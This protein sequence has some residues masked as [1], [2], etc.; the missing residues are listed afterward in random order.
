MDRGG[1]VPCEGTSFAA[2]FVSGVAALVRARYPRLTA[3]QTRERIES[4]ADHPST[5][6]PDARLGYGVVNPVAAVTAA[7]ASGPAAASA[8]AGAPPLPRPASDAAMRR[9]TTV[10]AAGSLGAVTLV[11][12]GWATLRRGRRR[13]WRP[14][15]AASTDGRGARTDGLAARTDATS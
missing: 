9:R 6:L 1:L 12:A 13:G 3:A 7:L 10:V 11:L 14:G 8:P 5:E 15:R 4:T 2:P